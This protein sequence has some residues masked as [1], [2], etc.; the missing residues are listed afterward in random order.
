M[1]AAVLVCVTN[2]SLRPANGNRRVAIIDNA[3]S[4]NDSAAN[5]FLQNSRGSHSQGAVLILIAAQPDR[6][7]P[8]IRSRCQTVQ[9]GPLTDSDV[10]ELLLEQELTSDPAAAQAVALL[11]EG[12]LETAV[13]LLDPNLQA[14]RLAVIEELGRH[15]FD[16][17]KTAERLIKAVEP[18]GEL[19]AQREATG[20]LARFAAEFFRAAGVSLAQP[21]PQ[22]PA[23]AFARRLSHGG[24]EPELAIDTLAD[25]TDRAAKIEDQLDLYTN[26]GL[27]IEAF[28][29][30]L[31][32]RLRATERVFS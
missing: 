11:A 24:S 12:S 9:F 3:D 2:W 4:M 29:H 5:A 14:L 1:P 7:L 10:C 32:G 6:L 22:G 13:Q 18:A 30:E 20:W 25:L 15:P 26:P 21:E 28:A 16:S 8:T 23:A 31:A 27:C 19:A 17:G